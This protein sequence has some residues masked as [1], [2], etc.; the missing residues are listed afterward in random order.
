MKKA[1]VAGLAAVLAV[2]AVYADVTFVEYEAATEAAA[3]HSHFCKNELR[4]GG[5][6]RQRCAALFE[7]LDRYQILSGK[8]QARMSGEGAEAFDGATG[9]R[10]ELHMRKQQQ[11]TADMHFINEMLR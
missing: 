4:T 3:T 1:W 9:S 11:L 2:G 5:Q 10:L 6:P 8:F 7:Y